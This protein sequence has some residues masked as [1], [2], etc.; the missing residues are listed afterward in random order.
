[1]WD[2]EVGPKS[3]LHHLLPWA[4]SKPG[5]RPSFRFL[6]SEAEKEEIGLQAPRQGQRPSEGLRFPARW[7]RAGSTQRLP[8]QVVSDAAG[9]ANDALQ[10]GGDV[11]PLC[12]QEQPRF[13]P[14]GSPARLSH[15]PAGGAQQGR[16]WV[17][18][19]PLW[20]AAEVPRHTCSPASPPWECELTDDGRAA[21]QVPWVSC[22]PQRDFP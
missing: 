1:M 12:P 21:A 9:T 13:P 8:H 15:S 17:W 7:P 18:E 19:P 4:T 20:R 10:P 22:T 3:L 14:G 11:L 16:S 5:N 2:S 6:L